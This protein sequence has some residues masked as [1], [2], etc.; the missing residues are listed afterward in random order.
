MV[1]LVPAALHLPMVALV[2]VAL[3]HLMVAPVPANSV[4]G[5]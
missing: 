2:L 5:K 1:A 4:K 3:H